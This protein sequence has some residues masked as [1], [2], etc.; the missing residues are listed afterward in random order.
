V[1][2]GA[3]TSNH[4]FYQPG[5]RLLSESRLHHFRAIFRIGAVLL[6]AFFLTGCGSLGKGHSSNASELATAS[7]NGANGYALLFQLVGDEKDLSKLRFL[8]HEPPALKNLANAIAATNRLAYKQLEELAKTY[9]GLNLRTNG[10]PR[11]EK[12]T[13][14]S[15]SKAKEKAL[16]SG[17][18][19]E[20]QLQLLLSQNEGLTYGSHLAKTT[21]ASEPAP[22]RK[23]MLEQIGSELGKLQEQVFQMILSSYSG[24]PE[25]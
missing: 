5:V 24:I 13:R 6:A 20:F 19:K 21:A 23:Q 4:K 8:K 9:T 3:P 22:G 17:K 18:G 7:T 11:S 2:A 15:I 12:Q 25:K 14:E 1:I 16:L 10:L